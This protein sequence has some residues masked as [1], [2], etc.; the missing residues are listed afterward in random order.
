M[1]KAWKKPDRAKDSVIR[2]YIIVRRANQIARINNDFK[3]NIIKQ[4]F[5]LKMTNYDKKLTISIRIKWPKHSPFRTSVVTFLT[6]TKMRKHFQRQENVWITV[7]WASPVATH[8]LEEEGTRTGPL[9]LAGTD[10]NPVHTLKCWTNVSVPAN[11]EH[12]SLVS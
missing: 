2:K 1:D 3:M 12:S 7:Y 11:V 5:F 10:F 8:R 4:F 9:C 6:L